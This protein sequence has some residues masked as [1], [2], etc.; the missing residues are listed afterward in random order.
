MKDEVERRI[1]DALQHYQHS[2]KPSLRASAEKFGIGYSSLR[3][4]LVGR[5]SRAKRHCK[6][7]VLTEYQENSIV[8]W[9]RRLEEWGHPACINVV[10]GMAEAMIA[11][12]VKDR[13]L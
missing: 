3:G 6:R 13:T 9:C 10:K 7:H 12:R 1:Q 4:R 5:Q 11:R 2:D 8:Q